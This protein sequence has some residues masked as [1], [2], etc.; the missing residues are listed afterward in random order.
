MRRLN[1]IYKPSAP[2]LLAAHNEYVKELSYRIG[3][4]KDQH[5][6][7]HLQR[8]FIADLKEAGVEPNAEIYA[9][10]IQASL[11]T[12]GSRK[13][14]TVRRYVNL[15]KEAEMY[16]ETMGFLSDFQR[17]LVCRPGISMALC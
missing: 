4:T 10:M 15:A 2:G 7:E 12:S 17:A 16:E 1:Q 11:Q 9:W 5:L 6:L 14:R 8:W 13:D 3:Q